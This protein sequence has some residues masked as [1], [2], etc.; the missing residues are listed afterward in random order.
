MNGSAKH[1]RNHVMALLALRRT[2]QGC[3]AFRLEV[4]E[5][6]QRL[7]AVATK[8]TA[9]LRRPPFPSMQHQRDE[10]CQRQ[11]GSKPNSRIAEEDRRE[12]RAACGPRHLREAEQGRREA[13]LASEWR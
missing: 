11:H 7:G 13:G 10:G 9:R 2:I 4:N 3:R 12:R 6:T 8:S 1:S 5:A